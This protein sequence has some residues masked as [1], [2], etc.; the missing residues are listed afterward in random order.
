MIRRTLGTPTLL[1]SPGTNGNAL[2]RI[3]CITLRYYFPHYQ[4]A[5]KDIFK[6]A[7][8]YTKEYLQKE[9]DTVRL[10]RAAKAKGGFY[11]EPEAK[12][13]F[14]I[15]LRGINDMDPQ[16]RKILQLLRLRQI[17][18]GV[19]IKI[20]KATLMMLRR[21]EPYIMWGYPNLKSVKEL[22]YKRGFGKVRRNGCK[23]NIERTLKASATVMDISRTSYDPETLPRIS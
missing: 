23:N 1:C 19:F 9:Q 5:R 6:R 21:V 3:V 18:N 20:N 17:N 10:R 22:I 16:T 4:A 15:R 8:Q 11:V 2:T 12:L 7:E 14:V 13:A